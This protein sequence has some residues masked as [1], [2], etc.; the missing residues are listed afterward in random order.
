MKPQDIIAAKS[1]SL[2][3]F[4]YG[5]L[6]WK[7]DFKY[8]RSKVGFIRGY[9]RRFWHGDNFHRGSDELPARVVT[10][11][12]DDDA[13]TWGVAFEVSGAQV[14]AALEYLNVREAVRGGY[15]SEMVMFHPEDNSPSVPAL[16]YIA[17]TDNPLY[18]GPATPAE[19]G[20]R[21]AVCEGRTGHNLEYLLRL[22]AFMR[23]SCPHVEDH[24][25][26]AVE[27]AAL[28]VVTYLLEAQ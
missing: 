1:S 15:N 4:G 24:H 3:I 6:V 19:I 8:K 5:S 7:P 28:A 11:I 10:L 14:E 9:K 17:T 20:A 22:A 23:T 12:P 21:I 25:L 26:Y 18:M 13:S 27:S 2:W 16:L